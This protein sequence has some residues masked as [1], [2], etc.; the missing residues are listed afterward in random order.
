MRTKQALAVK[1]SSMT[2]NMTQHAR[3][4]LLHKSGNCCSSLHIEQR[5]QQPQG[6][7]R[8]RPLC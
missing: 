4:L 1:C 5:L 8:Q 3:A 7:R 2:Q 6:Y